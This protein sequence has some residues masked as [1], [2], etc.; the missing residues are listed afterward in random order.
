MDWYSANLDD[1]GELF[2]QLRDDLGHAGQP[3]APLLDL[4]HRAERV[5]L[6]FRCSGG[7]S[8]VGEKLY[9]ALVGKPTTGNVYQCGSAALWPFLAVKRVQMAVDGWLMIHP[10]HLFVG[11][12]AAVLRRQL[13]DLILLENRMKALFTERRGIPA[14]IVAKWFNGADHWFTAEQALSAGL[15]HEV[16]TPRELPTRPATAATGPA[17][18][19]ED[20]RERALFD[21]LNC[22]GKFQTADKRKFYDKLNGWLC[23]NLK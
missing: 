21:F 5:E 22:L 9:H 1:N 23:Y 18:A 20:W 15:V 8:I 10:P 12:P 7:C 6:F 2:L 13:A 4:I 3:V 19:V 16:F 17:P 11:S 14:A